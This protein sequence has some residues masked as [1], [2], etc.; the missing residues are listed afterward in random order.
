M[1]TQRI[2]VFAELG[3]VQ[4]IPR[5][6]SQTIIAVVGSLSGGQAVTDYPVDTPTRVNSSADY[7]ASGATDGDV[8]TALAQVCL[9]Y[10][11]PSPR[12]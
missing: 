6:S 1:T 12:D 2:G 9:L 10:T 3:T 11:S 5:P 8:H 7:T 4:Q